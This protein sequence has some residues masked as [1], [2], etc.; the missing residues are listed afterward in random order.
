MAYNARVFRILIA[1]PGDVAKERSVVTEVIQEWND[2]NSKND[3]LVLL[4]LRWETHSSPKLGDRPQAIINAQVVDKCD[5]VI[6]V[7]WTKLGTPTGVSASGTVEEIERVVEA[8]KPVMLYFSRANIDVHSL[9]LDEIRRLRDFKAL[10]SSTGL[11]EDYITIDEFK[12]KLRKQLAFQVRDLRL[13][14]EFV[15]DKADA[16]A[17]AGSLRPVVA[18]GNSLEI[19]EGV[20]SAEVELILCTDESDI[21]DFI[22][23]KTAPASIGQVITFENRDYYRRLVDY[24]RSS[25]LLVPLRMGASNAANIGT[26][27]ALMEVGFR[28]EDGSIGLR[29]D[30][31]ER[32]NRS[33]INFSFHS[34]VEKSPSLEMGDFVDGYQGVRVEFPVI[35][36]RRTLLSKNTLFIQPSASTIIHIK[37]A[38]YSNLSPPLYFEKR[39]MIFARE[40]R[41]SF[42]EIIA[43]VGENPN[44][45]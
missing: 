29:L 35:Q 33:G 15:S 6:G 17:G 4:P 1:S 3:G 28:A 30:A 16:P 8:G 11:V 9:D 43:K 38:V 40:K 2:V 14:D 10:V 13:Q 44:S 24:V 39:L 19:L 27:D 36:A 18:Y 12:D 25:W 5:M 23:E 41:L 22:E 42:R 31:P 7:F 34:D 37:G 21:P 32:P 45:A 26:R 20:G